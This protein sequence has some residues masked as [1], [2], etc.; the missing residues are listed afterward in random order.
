LIYT[1]NENACH[2]IIEFFTGRLK[3]IRDEIDFLE[4]ELKLVTN[5]AVRSAMYEA[6]ARRKNDETFAMM[7]IAE[8]E[9]HLNSTQND[10]PPA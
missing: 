2:I 6:L 8:M 3:P 1:F 10:E 4:K 9:Q 7:K 5:S